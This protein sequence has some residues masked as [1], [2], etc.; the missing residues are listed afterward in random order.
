MAV[1]QTSLKLDTSH[2]LPLMRPYGSDDHAC[3]NPN[4]LKATPME[5]DLFKAFSSAPLLSTY[6]LYLMNH[7]FDRVVLVI[8]HIILG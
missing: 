6:L 7:I 4:H 2:A 5:W 8:I 3:M 1:L